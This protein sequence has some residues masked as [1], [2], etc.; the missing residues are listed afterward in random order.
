MALKTRAIIVVNGWESAAVGS[1]LPHMYGQV[2]VEICPLFPP[3]IWLEIY[4]I[5]AIIQ[6]RLTTKIEE[7]TN[8]IFSAKTALIKLIK[9]II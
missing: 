7:I 6:N 2:M 8:L 4:L 1:E 3:K 9:C 5:C